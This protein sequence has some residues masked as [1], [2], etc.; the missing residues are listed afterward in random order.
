MSLAALRPHFVWKKGRV[1]CNR[2][3]RWWKSCPC[4]G[5]HELRVRL[6][7]EL[8]EL[9]EPDPL[10]YVAGARAVLAERPQ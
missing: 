10:A 3:G 4:P 7:K 9:C 5:Q 6:T 2:H 8:L 1:W